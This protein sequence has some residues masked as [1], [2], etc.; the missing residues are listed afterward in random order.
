MLFGDLYGP[1]YLANAK[2]ELSTTRGAH[3][4]RERVSKSILRNNLFEKY[5]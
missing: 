2:H 1:W 4:E 5:T 3:I